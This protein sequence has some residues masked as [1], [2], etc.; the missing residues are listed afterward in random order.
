MIKYFSDTSNILTNINRE[1]EFPFPYAYTMYA[2]P[3][4][5]RLVESRP[6][7]QFIAQGNDE[8]NKRIDLK[9]IDALS[10]EI[11]LVW[12]DFIEYHTSEAFYHKILDR[13]GA[14][15]NEFYPKDYRKLKCGLRYRDQADIYLDCQIGINTPV[16]E[17]GTVSKPHL[18]NPNELFA[19]LFYMPL[20]DDTAGGD[21][22]IYKCRDFPRM[23]DKRQIMSE[24]LIEQ[25]IIPYAPNTM[26]CFMNSPFSIHS[27]TER[28]V[29]EKPRL[30]V[31]IS[32]EFDKPLFDMERMYG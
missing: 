8:N 20:P 13:F 29:T 26:A 3:H 14:Y 25:K 31:N 30:L 4:Y 12:R 5:Q 16:K 7:W 27:V 18:D 15:F 32:L 21:L 10:M 19:I 1:S 2:T 6:S 24:E 28:E 9:A 17:K 23:Y 22:V 11:P